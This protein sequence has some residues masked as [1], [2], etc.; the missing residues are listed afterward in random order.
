MGPGGPS[1][2]IVIK[3][4]QKTLSEVCWGK[5]DLWGGKTNECFAEGTWNLNLDLCNWQL[6]PS[7]SS[8]KK[9]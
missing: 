1:H 4:V 6:F 9:S 2:G 8:T 5:G 3:T 7:L